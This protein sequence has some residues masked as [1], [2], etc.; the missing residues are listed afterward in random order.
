MSSGTHSRKPHLR[1]SASLLLAAALLGPRPVLAQ[2]TA[3]LPSPYENHAFVETYGSYERDSSTHGDRDV[4]WTDTF[5]REKLTLQSIGY[6]Y[7]PRF[8]QY[9]LSLSGAATQENYDS[10]SFNSGDWKA[11]GAFEYDARLFLLPEHPYNLQLFASRR[12]PTFKQQ[13]ATRH[14]SVADTYGTLFRYRQKPYFLNAGFVDTTLNSAGSSS[15]VK[16]LTLDGEYF[17]RFANGYEVSMSGAAKPSWYEDSRNLLGTTEEYMLSNFVNLKSA[18]LNSSLTQNS[19]QQDRDSSQK[20]DSDQFQWWEMLSL[21]LPLNFRTN[22]TYRYHDDQSTVGSGSEPDR[23]FSD[24]GNNVQFDVIQRLYE[25]V[26]TTYRLV[27]DSRASSGGDTAILSHGLSLDYNK[28]IPRGRFATGVS[29]GRTETDNSGFVDVV[30]DPYTATAVPSTFALHQQ[31]VDPDSI[32]VLLKSPLPPFETIALVEGVHYQKNTSVEPFEIQ[33]FGLPPEFVIP[34]DYDFYVSYSLLGGD[35]KLRTDTLG[36]NLTVQLFDDLLTPFFRYLAQRSDV[37]S[38]DFPGIP[39]DSDTYT[40]GLLAHYGAVRARGEY[41]YVDWAANPHRSWLAEVRYVGTIGRYTNA[42]ATTT[43]LNRHYLGGDGLYYTNEYT[44][45]SVTTSAT[46]TRQLPYHD[47][48]VSLGGSYSNVHGMVESNAW[49]ANS[50]F[51]WRIGKV[52]LNIGLTAYG[53]D[54]SGGQGPTTDRNRELFYVS[55]RR[56]LF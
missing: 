48:Y 11:A 22:L 28:R 38:G 21:N 44:E 33:I 49:S 50:S 30:N 17:K 19:F 51:V 43:Y 24:N 13:A 34:G 39:V 26:D 27:H 45:Q 32:T 25:S 7:D 36:T 41:Q 31:N 10:S 56:Q 9:Q 55:V 2:W 3:F 18:R 4:T 47:M 54:T 37:L 5:F 29:L 42:Y 12:E 23:T 8:L 20:Y 6:S 40:T 35:F 16:R 53:A 15:D 52:D 1:I 46:L 14:D